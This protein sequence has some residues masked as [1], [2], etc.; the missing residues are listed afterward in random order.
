VLCRDLCCR[1][2]FACQLFCTRPEFF[3]INDYR[4]AVVP[5]VRYYSVHVR[6]NNVQIKDFPVNDSKKGLKKIL[7]SYDCTLQA[8]VDWTTEQFLA[9]N[10]VGLEL[11][12]AGPWTRRFEDGRAIL[13]PGA[14]Q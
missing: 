4:H 8:L 7:M 1:C 13:A 6:Y 10:C 14:A 12:H 2:S 9:C 5:F 11:T 3:W